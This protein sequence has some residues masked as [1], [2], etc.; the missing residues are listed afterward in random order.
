MMDYAQDKVNNLTKHLRRIWPKYDKEL[1][2]QIVGL[3]VI[4]EFFDQTFKEA[5]CED[6]FEEYYSSQDLL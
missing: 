2:Q 5:N 3:K 1:K 4:L 6:D